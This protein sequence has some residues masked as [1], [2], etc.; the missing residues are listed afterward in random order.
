MEIP[1]GLREV[2][3]GIKRW[4][5]AAWLYI[6]RFGISEKRYLADISKSE[7]LGQDVVLKYWKFWDDL[8]ID[9]RFRRLHST[10]CEA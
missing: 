9:G 5:P 7:G 10:S 6:V 3:E 1:V 8:F 4:L 2:A